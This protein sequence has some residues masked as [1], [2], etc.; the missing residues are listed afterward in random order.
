M[1]ETRPQTSPVRPTDNGSSTHRE[2]RMDYARVAPGALRAQFGMEA[3]VRCSG[4]ELSLL[5]LVRL[6]AS[7]INGCA[8]CVDMHTKDAR[9]AGET[10]QRLY[11]VSVWRETPFFTAHERAALS[12]TETI[13]EIARTGVSDEAF[14][15]AREQFSEGELAALTTAVITINGWNRFAVAFR[16]PVGDYQPGQHAGSAEATRIPEPV[17]A[18]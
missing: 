6:R 14:A 1:N 3:Y 10:E 13:T 8:Y 4:L 2:P 12:W 9:F 15:E 11:A 18:A 17:G 5:E 7:L 16:A